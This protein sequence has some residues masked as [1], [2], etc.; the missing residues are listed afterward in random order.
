[1]RF[2]SSAIAACLL[3]STTNGKLC[4]WSRKCR[5]FCCVFGR[6]RIYFF[7][8]F[9]LVLPLRINMVPSYL[10]YWPNTLSLSLRQPPNIA[11]THQGHD[12]RSS[13][14][15]TS[16]LDVASFRQQTAVGTNIDE[17]VSFTQPFRFCFWMSL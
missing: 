15:S 2:Y 6:P 7:G 14:S 13:T 10:C 16:P 1:M 3:A 12:I 5:L 11:F 9:C 8:H 17:R 4:V